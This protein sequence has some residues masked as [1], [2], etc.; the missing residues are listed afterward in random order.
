MKLKQN[1]A[2]AIALLLG[3]ALLAGCKPNVDDTTANFGE[4]EKNAT[5]TSS[6][7]YSVKSGKV[8]L[9]TSSVTTA[10][11]DVEIK[12]TVAS[13]S[14]LN[15]ESVES[16]VS[17]YK[18]KNNT[19]NDMYYPMHDG[20]LSYTLDDYTESSGTNSDGESVI[21]TTLTFLVDMSGVT[22]DKVAFIVDATKLTD[23]KGNAVLNLDSDDK[24]GEETDSFI[25]Y[26]SVTYQKDGT[27]AT[28]LNYEDD[29]KEDFRPQYLE[30]PGAPEELRDSGGNYTGKLRFVCDAPVSSEPAATTETYDTNWGNTLSSF[31][32]FQTKAADATSWTDNNLTFTYHA[33]DDTTNG[34][35]PISANTFT[36][37]TPVLEAG[38]QWRVLVKKTSS[39]SAPSWFSK[40][41]GHPGYVLW[42]GSKDYTV[43]ADDLA[44]SGYSGTSITFVTEPSYIVDSYDSSATTAATWTPSQI[45]DSAIKSAQ[46]ALLNVT[47]KAARGSYSSYSNSIYT[48]PCSAW[49]WEITP[50]SAELSSAEDFIVTDSN[51]AVLPS[52][53]SVIKNSS[54]KITRIYVELENKNYK[55]NGTSSSYLSGTSLPS[56]IPQKPTLW[57]GHG[58]KIKENAAYPSQLEFGTY[59]NASLPEAV[60]GY[61]QIEADTATAK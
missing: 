35:A 36:A 29:Y 47:A 9:G 43:L 17:F 18:L 32:T 51:Y 1:R 44:G 25:D 7:T 10:E 52:T 13:Y 26:I 60:R 3:A 48:Y 31:V 24:A 45:S 20:T 54:G 27:A 50:A 61:V 5:T 2:G 12:A 58:T 28:E 30:I 49:A 39:L 40:V 41:Y 14:K 59:K 8:S 19:D 15:I 46:G 34:Y 56:S 33:E 23:K 42:T 16:A 38:T 57:V 11:K 55:V 21:E 53:V 6:G 22:T 4:A 37:D